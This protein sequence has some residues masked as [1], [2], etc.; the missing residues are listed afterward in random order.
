MT[1]PTSI[2]DK[3]GEHPKNEILILGVGN[4]LLGDE[5]V[6]VRVVEALMQNNEVPPGVD[7]LDGGT[8][9][10][11]LLSHLEGYST[12]I[13]VDATLD[14]QPAGSVSVL[15]PKFAKDYPP[16]LSAHD[17]G[18]KDLIES[19]HVLGHYP[20]VYLVAISVESLQPMTL[21]LTPLVQDAVA[22]AS[23]TVLAILA[24]IGENVIL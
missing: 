22:H 4:L 15:E 13:L 6:G 21:D 20:K 3:P 2:N 16:T 17:V 10:F 24:Q 7:L 9:G 19:L 14:G 8:G 12:I 5:G 11:H 1:A 18:L 23:S